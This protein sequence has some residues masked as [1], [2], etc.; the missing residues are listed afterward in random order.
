MQKRFVGSSLF[1]LGAAIVTVVSAAGCGS[2]Y[3][4]PSSP[5]STPSAT[6]DVV[7]T[8]N[9]IN[10]GMSFSPASATAKVGQTVAWKNGD[11][12]THDVEQ[13]AGGGFDTGGVAGGA[14][15][16]PIKITTAGALPYHCSIHPSM[17]GML[18]VQ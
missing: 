15:S 11:S 18:T 16:K 10:G 17:V 7:I 1:F 2:S 3:S 8:I 13:D 4:S 12:I 6:A 9:G 5:S 14:T